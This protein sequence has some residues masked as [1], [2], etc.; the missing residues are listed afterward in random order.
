[1]RKI[2]TYFTSKIVGSITAAQ[3]QVLNNRFIQAGGYHTFRLCR[4]APEAVQNPVERAGCKMQAG[5]VY[6]NWDNGPSVRLN[7][8]KS[9]WETSSKVVESSRTK[10][11]GDFKFQTDEQLLGNQPDIVVVDKEQ[12]AAVVAVPDDSNII[13]KEDE[14]N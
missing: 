7:D 14:E 13:R 5:T 4:G 12:K 11:L 8:P 2:R 3:E 9:Q 6:S 10:I 1:M